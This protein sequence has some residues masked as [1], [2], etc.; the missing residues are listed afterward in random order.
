MLSPVRISNIHGGG[1]YV[2]L[3]M[4]NSCTYTLKYRTFLF[5]FF[6]RF[7]FPLSEGSVCLFCTAM[8]SQK[9]VWL[10]KANDSAT[11]NISGEQLLPSNEAWEQLV[12]VYFRSFVSDSISL[13]T[14]RTALCTAILMLNKSFII[15]KIVTW[16]SLHFVSSLLC[17]ANRW[18]T[19]LRVCY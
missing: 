13:P 17:E 7:F 4:E 5:F 3:R 19:K 11:Y 16:Q 6:F 18:W 14:D 15:F 1:K 2:C 9:S 12:L 10:L 8:S